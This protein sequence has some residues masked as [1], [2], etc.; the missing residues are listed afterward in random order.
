MARAN[1]EPERVEVVA[2][3][4]YK[5][6]ERPMYFLRAGKRVEVTRILDRWYGL[7][8]DYFKVLGDDG[9]LY[10]LSWHRTLDVWLMQKRFETMGR[11]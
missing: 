4:G 3:S 5:A 11:H 7:E 2:Y 1:E 8:R 9:G 6:N 10:L